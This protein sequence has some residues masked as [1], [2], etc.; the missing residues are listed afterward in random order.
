MKKIFSWTFGLTLC[1]LFFGT[2]PA[3]SQSCGGA[4]TPCRIDRGT[5]HVIVPESEARGAVVL[6]HGG[7]GR[8][9]GLLNTNLARLSL[10]RGFIFVAPNGEHP[11]ARFPRNWSVRADG[12]VF[13]KDDVPFL[14]DVMDHVAMTHGVDRSAMLLAGFSRGG[15]MVWDVACFA[16]DLARAYA[17]SAGAFWDVLP[18]DCKAPVDLFHTHGWNDRTVPLEGRSLRNGTV[19]QGDVWA[20]LKILRETNGC[21]ARQPTRSV[22]EDD[23]WFKHWEDCEAGRI[24]LMLHPGGHGSPRGWAPLI[25]D[26]FEERL[27]EDEG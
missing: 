8:G 15:S 12:T 16:P 22:I 26:W 17:P 23:R 2:D 14:G 24:D 5:Y 25:L 21:T 4:E 3:M 11:G 27:D 19:V 13:E 9:S 6:L 7:G 1:A 20:S 10:A 18:E